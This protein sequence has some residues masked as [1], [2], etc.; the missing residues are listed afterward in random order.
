MKIVCTRNI[1]DFYYYY[2]YLIRIHSIFSTIGHQFKSSG[3]CSYESNC[4]KQLFRSFSLEV[5]RCAY[6]FLINIEWKLHFFIIQ[7][8]P[9]MGTKHKELLA[10]PN[11]NVLDACLLLLH[12][13]H[14]VQLTIVT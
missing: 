11:S 12:N 2:F 8:M 6:F 9:D 3:T 14:H 13:Y 5:T 4:A 1:R 7:L 10:I